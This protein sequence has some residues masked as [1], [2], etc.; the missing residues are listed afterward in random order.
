MRMRSEGKFRPAAA[1]PAPARALAARHRTACLRGCSAERPRRRLQ[2]EGTAGIAALEE[3]AS[4]LTAHY[5]V[6]QVIGALRNTLSAASTLTGA[7]SPR[8]RGVDRQRETVC[9]PG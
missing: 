9:Q 3:R 2:G 5:T 1:R 7:G 6:L 4:S 8:A